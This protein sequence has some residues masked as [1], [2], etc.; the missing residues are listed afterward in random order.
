MANYRS[1]INWQIFELFY[2]FSVG[3]IT[4][5]LTDSEQQTQA[6]VNWLGLMKPRM[7]ISPGWILPVGSEQTQL[8]LELIWISAPCLFDGGLPQ[9]FSEVP[10]P[11]AANIPKHRSLLGAGGSCGMGSAAATT[12]CRVLWWRLHLEPFCAGQHSRA[13]GCIAVTALPIPHDKALH[14][15]RSKPLQRAGPALFTSASTPLI[16]PSSSFVFIS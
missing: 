4:I 9:A 15:P 6:M 7:W 2:V 16:C 13:A 14:P 5:L 3:R 10:R 11:L 12:G 8:S 1:C